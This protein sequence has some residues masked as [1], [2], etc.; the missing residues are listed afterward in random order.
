LNRN[1]ATLTGDLHDDASRNASSIVAG[2]GMSSAAIPPAALDDATWQETVACVRSEFA[3]F[4]LSFVDQR[5]Q[6]GSG[7]AGYMMVVFGGSGAELGLGV[8]SRG[9]SPFDRDGCQ[10]VERAV[11]FVFS[12]KLGGDAQAN[13]ETAAHEIAHIFSVDHE[14]LAADAMSH[15]PFTSHRSFQDL[16]VP[17]GESQER[18]CACGRASQNSVQILTEK[19]GLVE[20]LDT[21]PPSVTIDVARPQPGYA[22]FTVHATD[23]SGIATVSLTYR[24]GGSFLSSTCG[25]GKLPCIV[26]GSSY[27]FSVPGARGL[28]RYGAT[29]IDAAGNAATTPS[30]ELTVDDSPPDATPIALTIDAKSEK[31]VA[32]ARATITP[33]GSPITNVTLYFTDTRGVTT[34]RTLCPSA[35]GQWSRSIQL[36]PLAGPRSFVVV[37]T[38]S[39]GR[40]VLSPRADPMMMN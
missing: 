25:D 6:P 11:A 31:G 9:D 12:S 17:C 2:F 37:A 29:V 27:T 18:P 35:P 32:T 10:T 1:G 7:E 4:N 3:R 23:P 38:D 24:D 34:S 20:A 13:C 22:Q 28:A 8:D 19:L 36:A 16:D 14:L 33:S 26:D 40:S 15:I 39:D 21:T 30:A 5:P